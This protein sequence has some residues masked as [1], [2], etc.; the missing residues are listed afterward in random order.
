MQKRSGPSRGPSPLPSPARA[1]ASPSG[2]TRTTSSPSK[3]CSTAIQR[4]ASGTAATSSARS[5]SGRSAR[6]AA[7]STPSAR[8]STVF[9]AR[10]SKS[11]ACTW[12]SCAPRSP[13]RICAPSP[14][15]PPASRR[16]STS[17]PPAFS[18]IQPKGSLP[19]TTAEPRACP[20]SSGGSPLISRREAESPPSSARKRLRRYGSV[21]ASS[22][23]RGSAI[24]TT[25]GA[26][27]TRRGPH[28]DQHRRAHPGRG[29]Q[30]RAPAPRPARSLPRGGG[31]RG[32]RGQR[33]CHAGRRRALRSRGPRDEPAR[34]RAPDEC[35]GESGQGR[36]DPLPPRRY[37][38]A[39]RRAGRHR[40]GPRRRARGRRALRCRLQQPAPGLRHDR[41]LHERALA[42]EWNLDGGPGSL[43]PARRLRGHGRLSRHRPHGGHRI[44]PAPQAAR[45]AG[46]PADLRD[47][48][49][50]QV[51][52]R[53]RL[54]DHG[55]HVEPPLPLPGGRLAG[56]SPRL[57][58]SLDP[59]AETQIAGRT[60]AGCSKRSRCEAA[61]DGRTRGVVLYVERAAE[62]ANEADGPF[63][64]A[65]RLLRFGQAHR[66]PDLGDL[67]RVVVP[68]V[69]E[70]RAH[71]GGNVD[72]LDSHD[73]LEE[74]NARLALEVG[75]AQ[76]I[77]VVHHVALLTLE[78]GAELLEGHG[79]AVRRHLSVSRID[80]DD[81]EILGGEGLEEV[82][83]LRARLE[84]QVA[85]H[86]ARGPLARRVAPVQIR[87]HAVELRPEARPR[88]V[89]AGPQVLHLRVSHRPTLLEAPPGSRR[90]V[91]GSRRRVI[92]PHSKR[93]HRGLIGRS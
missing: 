74:G 88:L 31:H 79:L 73:L 85:E 52:A 67:S 39:P 34:A 10:R 66:L 48:L 28:P 3:P 87:V 61:P 77:E 9:S 40:R 46:C 51:G 44:L 69:L 30:S 75:L 65:C 62:G 2:S 12:P 32:R 13:V 25:T 53:G 71:E 64:A 93:Y 17:K 55:A 91:I 15:R 72:L 50:P 54:P 4:R 90:S 7:R 27:T 29:G 14:T 47:D 78:R 35:G 20:S 68:V 84:E 24:S 26:S 92:L 70:Q 37:A 45:E 11:L 49:R 76:G 1:S 22:P 86:L 63:S 42:V 59:A 41:L 89:G 80:A 60:A 58:L 23:T 33:G 8:S 6:W 81:G 82:Y 83:R 36:H 18:P 19:A 56:S 43:R 5:G 21:S 38:P 57:V 16:S